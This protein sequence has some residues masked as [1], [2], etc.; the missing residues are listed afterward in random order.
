MWSI[1]FVVVLGLF[2]IYFKK[3]REIENAHVLFIFL[4]ILPLTYT[5][6]GLQGIYFAIK[7]NIALT[8]CVIFKD[9]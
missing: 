8:S 3:I 9:S 5:H 2:Y 1:I 4:S 7:E 6:V